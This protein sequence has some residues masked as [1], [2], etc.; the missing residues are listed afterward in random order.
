MQVASRIIKHCAQFDYPKDKLQIQVLDDSTDKTLEISRKA[1]KKYKGEG[2][3]IE[4][5]HRTNRKGYKAGALERALPRAT[6]EFIAIF[7]ADFIP[8][9]SFLK[10]TLPHFVSPEVGVVQTR[11]THV[12][13]NYSLLTR[14]QA[15]QLNVHFMIEQSGRFRGGYFLQFNGTAGLWRKQTILDSGNWKADT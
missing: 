3:N 2:I 4:L 10:Q 13:E 7:D 15:F 12:N 14:L 8:S 6:G 11:W 1:V 5:I 9:R